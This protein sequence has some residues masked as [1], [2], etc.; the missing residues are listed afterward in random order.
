MGGPIRTFLLDDHRVV[1]EGV[2][3]MLESFDDIQVAGEAGTAGQGVQGI[4]Q[5]GPDV[6]LVDVRL[7]DGSGIEVIR[8]VRSRRPSIRCVIFTS[9][10]DDEAFFQAVVAGSSGYLVK[11]AEASTLAD[12]IRTVAGGGSLMRREVIDDLRRRATTPQVHDAVLADLTGQERRIMGMIVRGMTNR[13]I[14]LE[15]SLAEKTVRNY[16]SNILAKVGMKNRTQLAAYVATAGRQ[17]AR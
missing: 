2:K 15:L 7:P 13:E 12:A 11:D 10:A 6:A 8:E 5:H 3:R 17:A 9:F 14:A 1:R 16:V 4:L